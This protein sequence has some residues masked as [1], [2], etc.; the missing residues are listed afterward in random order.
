MQEEKGFKNI[1]TWLTLEGNNNP[2]FLNNLLKERNL[3]INHVNI[4]EYD[5]GV[6]VFKFTL[7]YTAVKSAPGTVA[8]LLACGADPNQDIGN[9]GDTIFN[10]VVSRRSK[11]LIQLFIDYGA[12]LNRPGRES[13][14]ILDTAITRTYPGIIEM[15]MDAGATLH[16]DHSRPPFGVPVFEPGYRNWLHVKQYALV[17]ERRMLRCKKVLIVLSYLKEMWY[18]DLIS[19]IIQVVWREKRNPA[20]N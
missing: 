15:L 6:C 2:T 4:L 5:D 12:D 19:M 7:L 1:L 11:D 18:K 13:A 20:W 3:D 8:T 16:L 10:W 9:N 14:G 17:L